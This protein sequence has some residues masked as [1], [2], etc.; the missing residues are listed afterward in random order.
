VELFNYYLNA[1]GQPLNKELVVENKVCGEGLGAWGVGAGLGAISMA[2]RQAAQRC[3]VRPLHARAC[4]R[5]PTLQSST[6]RLPQ[7]FYFSVGENPRGRFLRIS[8]SGLG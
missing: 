5:A 3:G 1:P 7:V 4:V 8:E 2:A 6:R